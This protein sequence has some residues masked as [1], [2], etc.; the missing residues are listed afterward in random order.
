MRVGFL[1]FSQYH[2][3]KPVGSTKI[4]AQWIVDN[5]KQYGPDIGEAEMYKIGQAYDALIY[6]KVYWVEHAKNFRG[7]KILDVCDPDFLSWNYPV[8]E[9]VGWVDAITTSTLPLAK[10]F[11]QATDKPVQVVLDR[12]NPG[13]IK[14]LKAKHVGDA[15]YAVW[16]GYSD[17]H[18]VLDETLPVLH[19]N[20]FGLIVVSD[21][22]YRMPSSIK[23]FELINYPWTDETAYQDIC[24]GDVVLNPKKK[25]GKWKYKSE[26]KTVIAYQLGMPVAHNLDELLA[27]RT[28]EA[29]NKAVADSQK[30]LEEDYHI[31]KS[32]CELKELIQELAE[33]KRDPENNP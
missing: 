3:R 27:L 16:Y 21:T 17:N 33:G 7:I 6:Q 31:S 15:K 4:R 14:K 10:I 29:R 13:V 22:P 9:M 32:V 2:G 26:N 30:L 1:S 12:V 8:M 11:A 18:S 23:G 19:K 5:W 20:G 24:R 25:R 28:A